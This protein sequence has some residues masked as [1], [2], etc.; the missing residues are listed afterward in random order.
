MLRDSAKRSNPFP[1]GRIPYPKPD[2]ITGPLLLL[3]RRAKIS[4]SV[5]FENMAKKKQFQEL[6][7]LSA[8]TFDLKRL[9][10]YIE[11]TISQNSIVFRA[12]RHQEGIQIPVF[13]SSIK[14]IEE[15]N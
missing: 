10:G 8:R 1:A 4:I 3:S 5:R 6:I 7:P 2:Y 14:K 15:T 13:I 12:L 9:V 11:G